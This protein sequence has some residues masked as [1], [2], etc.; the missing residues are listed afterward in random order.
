MALKAYDACS[1]GEPVGFAVAPQGESLRFTNSKGAFG[2]ASGQAFRQNCHT[3]A[4]ALLGSRTPGFAGRCRVGFK[5]LCAGDGHCN[6]AFQSSPRRGH[7]GRRW[8]AAM[9]RYAREPENPTKSCKVREWAT[10]QQMGVMSQHQGPA[11]DR[12]G[13]AIA[14]AAG[15]VRVSPEAGVAAA[16]VAGHG[17][18]CR[19]TQQPT[20]GGPVAAPT[21]PRTARHWQQMALPLLMYIGRGSHPQLEIKESLLAAASAA[22]SAAGAAAA[23][24]EQRAHSTGRRCMGQAVCG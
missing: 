13:A 12:P 4:C 1:S 18:Q 8:V 3:R 10:W 23:S 9:G 11:A 17:S 7:S 14:H 16:P 5:V 21:V 24:R 19:A 20:Y 22:A 6:S 15:S 2:I